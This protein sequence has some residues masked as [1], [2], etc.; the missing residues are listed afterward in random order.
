MGAAQLGAQQ[1]GAGAQHVGA[2]AQHE[3]LQHFWRWHFCLQHFCLQHFCLQQ[4]EPQPLLQHDWAGA[5]QVGAGAQHVTGAGAQHVGAGAQHVGAGAQHE[6]LQLPQR[7]KA[8]AS[9]TLIQQNNAAAA[10]KVIHFIM[11]ISWNGVSS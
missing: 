2:G 5:Q 7:W 4:L 8:M 10:V 3:L 6:L 11:S 9:E 1:V